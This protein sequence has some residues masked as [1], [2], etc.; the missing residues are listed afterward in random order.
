M[1]RDACVIG[2]QYGSAPVLA[3]HPKPMTGA[4]THEP[5][6]DCARQRCRRYRIGTAVSATFQPRSVS[7]GAPAIVA[8]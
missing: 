2:H 6:E 4:V 8:G 7:A 3:S 1:S 5:P